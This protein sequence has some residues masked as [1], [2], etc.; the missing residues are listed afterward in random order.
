MTKLIL[1][2]FT[3]KDID[4]MNDLFF[5]INEFYFDEGLVK[6]VSKF[7]NKTLLFEKIIFYFGKHLS[8]LLK[9]NFPVGTIL[10]IFCFIFVDRL[11]VL[12]VRFLRISNEKGIRCKS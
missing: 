10:L 1:K 11:L 9:N 2:K 6:K 8:K 7:R 12:Q 4:K 3:K 5:V